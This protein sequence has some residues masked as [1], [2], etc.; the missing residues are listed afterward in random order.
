MKLK[1]KEEEVNQ[2]KTQFCKMDDIWKNVIR[3]TVSDFYRKNLTLNLQSWTKY[4]TQ[5]KEIQ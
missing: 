1:L 4:L 5:S 2:K 3:Q